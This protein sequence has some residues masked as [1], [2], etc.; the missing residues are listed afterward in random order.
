[1]ILVENTTMKKNSIIIGLLCIFLIAP[2]LVSAATVTNEGFAQ[3]LRQI[4]FEQFSGSISPS[5]G[6]ADTQD[7]LRFYLVHVTA[8]TIELS[9]TFSS[10]KSVSELFN[11]ANQKLADKN[12]IINP[13]EPN[14]PGNPSYTYSQN[15]PSDPNKPAQEN[16]DPRLVT[17]YAVECT[18]TPIVTAPGTIV[19]FVADTPIRTVDTDFTYHWDVFNNGSITT[20]NW[21]YPTIYFD[22]GV[23]TPKVTVVYGSVSR[24]LSCPTITVA[25]TPNPLCGN[26]IIDAGEECDDRY[27]SKNCADFGF[28]GGT[29]QCAA[30][31]TFDKTY[32]SNAAPCIDTDG[33]IMKYIKGSAYIAGYPNTTRNDTCIN[34]TYLNEAYC[35]GTNGGYVAQYCEYN[36]SNSVCLP[37]PTPNIPASTGMSNCT[38]ASQN[39]QNVV[40]NITLSA[41][42]MNRLFTPFPSYT[43]GVS[44]FTGSKSFALT[45]ST[46]G[47]YHLAPY[48]YCNGDYQNKA[49]IVCPEITVPAT[50]TGTLDFECTAVNRYQQ[51]TFI[52][53][54]ANIRSGTPPFNY[55]YNFYY[56]GS[57]SS[58]P[59]IIKEFTPQIDGNHVRYGNW[60]TTLTVTDA[61][62]NARTR[63]CPVYGVQGPDGS[64]PSDGPRTLLIPGFTPLTNAACTGVVVN[65]IT[66]NNLQYKLAATGGVNPRGYYLYVTRGQ[67]TDIYFS[68][69]GDF[70]I[71]TTTTGQYSLF[72]IIYDQLKWTEP[73]AINCPPATVK[74]NIIASC[75]TNQTSGVSPLRVKY[76][77]TASGGTPPYSAIYFVNYSSRGT[78]YGGYGPN[79]L[80]V[81]FEPNYDAGTYR[82]RAVVTDATGSISQVNVNCPAV[83]VSPNP[84]DNIA[85]AVC[86]YGMGG[87]PETLTDKLSFKYIVGGIGDYLGNYPWYLNFTWNVDDIAP[88][89]SAAIV[90]N[91]GLISHTYA[92]VGK[93]NARV[94]IDD[95]FNGG[96][97]IL[98]CPVEIVIPDP[99]TLTLVTSGTNVGLNINRK[100][101]A[102]QGAIHIY[103]TSHNDVTNKFNI[104]YNQQVAEFNETTADG[105]KGMMCA[106]AAKLACAAAYEQ[107]PGVLGKFV[108][109]RTTATPGTYKITVSMDMI[110]PFENTLFSKTID[111][112]F[113]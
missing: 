3:V 80:S 32:C 53:Y 87:M 37:Q 94:R 72:G 40:L 45:L 17:F 41:S 66:G 107:G 56:D 105:K 31:C 89:S 29:L 101:L 44:D 63:V 8:P 42:C 14:P 30:D 23:Y 93:K 100:T 97:R 19:Q 90:K 35:S 48:T 113:N 4:L 2:V 77:V 76:S 25:K 73:Y 13:Q 21:V 79:N 78:E 62:N 59:R 18:A 102:L 75:T 70:S 55:Q 49:F 99:N 24:T 110:Y 11:T 7:L 71:S 61:N 60:F 54:G 112:T 86:A 26:G 34:N 109:M 91:G 15:N 46:P 98:D 51:Y 22:E 38:I 74:N 104:T 39:G 111:M 36:C 9:E 58:E 50:Q 69:T 67:K 5:L 95:T 103:D 28:L 96:S 27:F 92:T 16:D 1:M 10:G 81:P 33:G 12:S 68:T 47:K 84:K 43:T 57:S 85:N 6:P 65:T 82:V 20:V 83:Q 52:E 64:W 108:I 106:F 88:G